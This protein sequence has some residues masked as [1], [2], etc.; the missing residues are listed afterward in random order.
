MDW[1][2]QPNLIADS[3]RHINALLQNAVLK[4]N[5]YRPHFNLKGLTPYEYNRQLSLEV[6]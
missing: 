5:S 4:Y 2:Y 6:V 1:L 3:I